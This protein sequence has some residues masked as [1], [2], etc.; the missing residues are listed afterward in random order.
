MTMRTSVPIKGALK[1]TGVEAYFSTVVSSK[2]MPLKQLEP[3]KNDMLTI[4]PDDELIDMKYVFQTRHTKKT[5]GERI[6]SP[7]GFFGVNETYINND[8]QMVL[9]HLNKMYGV[10]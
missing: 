8:A 7:I 3:Y 5:T 10:K 6:R 1:N 2:V 4:T 9:D